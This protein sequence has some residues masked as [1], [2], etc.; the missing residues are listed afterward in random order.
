MDWIEVESS[1]LSS[2]FYDEE[3]RLLYIKFKDTGHIFRYVHVS[4]DVYQNLKGGESKGTYFNQYIKGRYE[5]VRI[6]D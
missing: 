5:Y 3:N 2:I 6:S 1:A 4:E